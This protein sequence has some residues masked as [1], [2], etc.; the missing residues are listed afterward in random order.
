MGLTTIYS[1]I[2]SVKNK[3]RVSNPRFSNLQICSK[4]TMT[5]KRNSQPNIYQICPIIGPVRKQELTV[6]LRLS[7]NQ[8]VKNNLPNCV[9]DL[10]GEVADNQQLFQTAQNY[11]SMPEISV[12]FFSTDFCQPVTV[13]LSQI[14]PRDRSTCPDVF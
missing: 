10:P 8:S 1:Q 2:S 11:F 4:L 13:T 9:S 6:Q 3:A 14:C 5:D 7:K 12:F